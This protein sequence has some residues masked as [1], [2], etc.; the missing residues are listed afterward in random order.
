MTMLGRS[1]LDSPPEIRAEGGTPDRW[2]VFRCLLPPRASVADAFVTRGIGPLLRELQA[3]GELSGWSFTRQSPRVVDIHLLGGAPKLLAARLAGLCAAVGAHGPMRLPRPSGPPTP[4]LRLVD[5]AVELI[6]MT[7][8]RP[9]RLGAAVDLTM[10]AAVR[11][12]PALRVTDAP[13]VT[14]AQDVA[15]V[16]PARW[17]RIAAA[18]ATEQHPLTCW[19]RLLETHRRAPDYDGAAAFGMVHLLH[20]QLGLTE[21]DEQRVHAGLI[22]SMSRRSGGPRRSPRWHQGVVPPGAVG[23]RG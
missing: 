20:N 22:R 1:C 17:R 8:N 3:V 4:D 18:L 9:A 6:G 23:R 7:P 11:T 14:G 2:H 12:C 21:R 15:V 19:S 16:P 10:V 13:V 5:V